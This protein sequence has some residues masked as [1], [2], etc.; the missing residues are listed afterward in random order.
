MSGIDAPGRLVGAATGLLERRLDRRGLVAKMSLVGA[1]VAAGGFDF[2]LRPGTAYSAV[3]GTGSSCRSGWTAMCCTIHEGVNQCPPGT[4]AGGWWKA[5]G[6]SLCGGKARY[7]VDCQA[8]CTKCGCGRG[9]FCRRGCAN[10]KS[11]CAKG[12]CDKRKTCHAMFRYGQC[13]RDIDCSGPIS[14]RAISCTPPWKWADC[15]KT[16]ATDNRTRDHAASCL[17]RWSSIMKRYT[18]MGSQGSVLGASIGV[19]YDGK[20]GRIQRY[21]KG[22]MYWSK[23]TGAHWLDKNLLARYRVVGQGTLG[24][25]IADPRSHS[26]GR[27]VDFERG[28][29]YQANGRDAYALWGAIWDR[30]RGL[31]TVEGPLGFPLSSFSKAGDGRGTGARFAGGVI[32]NGPT[33]PT[34]AVW[35]PAAVAYEVRGYERGVLGYPTVEER[36]V[37]DVDGVRAAETLFE[38]GTISRQGNTTATVWGAIHAYWRAAGG[39]ASSFGHPVTDV[40]SPDGQHETCRFRHG[41]LT[42]DRA[43][44]QVSPGP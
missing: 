16:A 27:G 39:A 28:G 24:L 13:N 3:C 25:P 40:T 36:E 15:S 8:K 19:E 43:T 35:G 32:L 42:Y 6:A 22:R 41:S 26:G 7:Y 9:H 5:A 11:R 29:I 12:S 1:A 44:G 14:C 33:T 37:V 10:C 20:R 30:W 17:P 2:I 23:E 38:F 18:E 34:T 21:Q 31:G 4:F